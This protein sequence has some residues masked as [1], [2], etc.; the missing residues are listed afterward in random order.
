[1]AHAFSLTDG[2]TT[3]SLTTSGIM[4]E[5]YGMAAPQS[6]LDQPAP[7]SVTDTVDIY[8]SGATGAAVQTAA[9]ALDALLAQA[10]RRR[11]ER[12][13]PR[14]YVQAQLDSDTGV[15]RSELLNGRMELQEDA[16]AVWANKLARGTLYLER[17]PYWEGP[18]TGIPLANG[19]GTW[20]G[21]SATGLAVYNCNDASGTAPNKRNN[22]VQIAATDVVGALPAPVKLELKNAIG[23]SETWANFYL[24]NNAFSDP[25]NLTTILEGE[26]RVSGGT[27]TVNGNCSGGNVTRFA[28]YSTGTGIWTISAATLQKTQGRW[29]RLLANVYYRTTTTVIET[30][31]ASLWDSASVAALWRGPQVAIN[32]ANVSDRPLIDLGLVPLPPAAYDASFGALRL[33]VDLAVASGTGTTDI[34]FLQLTPV[35]SYRVLAIKAIAV[36]NNALVVDN[37]IDGLAYVEDGGVRYPYLQPGS[38]PLLVYPGKLQRIYVLADRPGATSDITN[39]WLARLWFRPRRVTL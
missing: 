31:Q 9:R 13:G 17:V 39:K 10:I 18:E 22:Y 2:T 28:T 3:I 36:A 8:I 11:A 19:N 4:L 38:A 14:V 16:L 34:D 5:N 35:D 33:Q 6:E 29:F 12:T 25:A 32:R 23:S 21:S 30:M 26:A 7:V 24:A 20:D 1:M 27:V 37:G 15:W